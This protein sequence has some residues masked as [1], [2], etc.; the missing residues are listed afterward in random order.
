MAKIGVVSIRKFFKLDEEGLPYIDMSDASEDD[1]AAIEEIT[2]DVYVEGRGDQA[3][4]VRSTKFKLHSKLQALER[5]GKALG[6]FDGHRSGNPDEEVAP[7]SYTLKI[8]NAIINV[9]SANNSGSEAPDSAIRPT[10]A[11]P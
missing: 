11:L 4:E 6:M 2:T 7:V 8:G 10:V 5:M 9:S 1:W 3:R